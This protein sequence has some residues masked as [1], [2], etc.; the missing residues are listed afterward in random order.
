MLQDDDGGEGNGSEEDS[1][2]PVMKICDATLVLQP[3]ETISI[4]VRL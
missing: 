3:A 1:R 2:Q 4:R